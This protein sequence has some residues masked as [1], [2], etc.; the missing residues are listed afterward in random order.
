MLMRLLLARAGLGRAPFTDQA[1]A[2]QRQLRWIED[3][4]L[5]QRDVAGLRLVRVLHNQLH[6]IALLAPGAVDVGTFSAT[7]KPEDD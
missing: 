5:A 1:L 2:V 3:H 7:P 6:Q 4:L